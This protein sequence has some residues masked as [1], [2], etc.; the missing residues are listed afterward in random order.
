M[1]KRAL[2]SGCP[3]LRET[4]STFSIVFTH[5]ESPLAMLINQHTLLF[6]PEAPKEDPCTG[7]VGAIDANCQIISLIESAF[8]NAR[9]LAEQYYMTSPELII[10]IF[11]PDDGTSVWRH[12]G[13]LLC[14]NYLLS[15]PFARVSHFVRAVQ[16]RRESH[17]RALWGRCLE[18]AAY[19]SVGDQRSLRRDRQDQRSRRRHS[20]ASHSGGVR[21]P[22][23]DGAKSSPGF[24]QRGN[25]GGRGAI[26]RKQSVPLAGYGYGLPLSRLYARYLT[27][28]L[29]LH[30]MD[31]FGTDAVLHLQSN[32]SFAKERLPV[33]HETG[34]KKIYEAHLAAD[35]WTTRRQWWVQEKEERN[36]RSNITRKVKCSLKYFMSSYWTAYIMMMTIKIHLYIVLK[37]KYRPDSDLGVEGE[38]LRVPDVLPSWLDVVS[39]YCT[40]KIKNYVI[41]EGLSE[42]ICSNDA[43][44][45]KR[46]DCNS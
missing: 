38:T 37:S 14:Q 31:G 40:L 21:L 30:S 29:E 43:V 5:L 20:Q 27:G 1:R 9:F 42:S 7:V 25:V 33:W 41:H 2:L 39:C 23:H 36:P 3:S 44:A 35:D 45:A 4:S 18:A 32:P 6:G 22:L 12:A 28:D 19:R 24:E 26:S 16:K 46:M 11:R 8:D 17:H 10:S 15:G 34:S 13:R